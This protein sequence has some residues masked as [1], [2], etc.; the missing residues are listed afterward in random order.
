M[1]RSWK[2][3]QELSLWVSTTLSLKQFRLIKELIFSH[4]F[5]FV[6]IPIFGPTKGFLVSFVSPYFKSY[7]LRLI[8]GPQSEPVIEVTRVTGGGTQNQK[9]DHFTHTPPLEILETWIRRSP[10]SV[11]FTLDQLFV[12]P[13]S[14][15]SQTETRYF[16]R[17][18][19]N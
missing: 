19:R 7:N 17:Y 12:Y 15:Q 1:C 14:P 8:C 3:K 13:D 9:R 2:R 16:V 4:N 5:Y 11:C 18:H 6:L 10:L